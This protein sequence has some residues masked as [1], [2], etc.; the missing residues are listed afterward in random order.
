MKMDTST[1]VRWSGR[2]LILAESKIVKDLSSC[3]R[4]F[5]LKRGLANSAFYLHFTEEKLEAQKPNDSLKVPTLNTGNV[6]SLT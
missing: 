1:R 5:E 3:H 4:I 2:I 6:F